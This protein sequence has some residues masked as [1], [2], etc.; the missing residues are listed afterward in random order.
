[1]DFL[2]LTFWYS[3]F[4][5]IYTFQTRWVS[6]KARSVIALKKNLQVVAAHLEAMACDI[7]DAIYF[8]FFPVPENYLHDA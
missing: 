5:N 1:M 3:T 8:G 4:P 6:S 2:S 7:P